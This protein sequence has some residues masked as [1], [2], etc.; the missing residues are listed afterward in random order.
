MVAAGEALDEQTSA[1]DTWVV[2]SN[3]GCGSGTGLG[4]TVVPATPGGT[5]VSSALRRSTAPVGSGAGSTVIRRTITKTSSDIK[6]LRSKRGIKKGERTKDSL[7]GLGK[8]LDKHHELVEQE[9]Q[10]LIGQEKVI[11]S[12]EAIV[13]LCDEYLLN[14]SRS[15]QQD[16]TIM[17]DDIRAEAH[18]DHGQITA[19]NRYVND[20]KAGAKVRER[21]PFKVEKTDTPMT[22]HF[23]DTIPFNA[24]QLS[25]G[26]A[27]RYQGAMGAKDDARNAA[28]REAGLTEAEIAAIKTFT[29]NDYLYLNPAVANDTKWL[30]NQMKE[31]GLAM[32]IARPGRKVDVKKM[33]AEGSTHAGVMMQGLAKLPAVKGKVYRGARMTSQE[34]QETY[35]SKTSITYGSFV[36]SSTDP[37]PARF[38]ASGGGSKP[39]RPDQTVSVYAVFECTDARDIRFISEAQNENEWLLLPGATFA[40]DKISDDPNFDRSR[41]ATSGK[42]V[43]LKQVPKPPKDD[44]PAPANKAPDDMIPAPPTDIVPPPEGKS[45]G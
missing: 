28:I 34:F 39:P 31:L 1:P 41:G 24:Q 6:S 40:I 11:G 29:A 37:V 3:A 35:G 38:Y 14:H 16:R 42:I 22:Q 36:S 30:G 45:R 27:T 25:K 17:V 21:D 18:R 5:G 9:K 15:R 10:G 20:L 44:P 4:R 43:H 13:W 2:R 12:L 23:N 7:H 19:Q 32:G 26:K 8:L 33:M